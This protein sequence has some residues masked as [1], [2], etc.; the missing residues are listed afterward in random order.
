M[1]PVPCVFSLAS[2][3][4]VKHAFNKVTQLFPRGGVHSPYGFKG[5]SNELSQTPVQLAQACDE[6]REF[7]LRTTIIPVL[8]NFRLH[9]G[10][11]T[12][13]S[14]PTS[15]EQSERDAILDVIRRNEQLEVAERQRVGRIVERVEKI[16]QRAAE[17]GP[18]NCRQRANMN[19]I[20]LSIHR[21]FFSFCLFLISDYAGRRLDCLGRRKLFARIAESPFAP[22]V[23]LSSILKVG[24]SKF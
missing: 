18:K 15:L 13:K 10:W 2:E 4:L 22:S 14:S 1:L 8:F 11:S 3:A 19:L 9:T 21:N 24:Q 5:T 12:G 16:K 17:C 23:R 7:P 20:F 6:T